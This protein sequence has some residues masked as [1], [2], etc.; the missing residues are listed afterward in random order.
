MVSWLNAFADG[1]AGWM[2]RWYVKSHVKGCGKC[3]GFLQD[4]VDNKLLL[5]QARS[6]PDGATL[7]RMEVAVQSSAETIH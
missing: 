2:M 4:I 6:G 3:R 7:Q 5:R 1:R